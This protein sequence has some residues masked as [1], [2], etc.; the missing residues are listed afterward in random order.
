MAPGSNACPGPR[1]SESTRQ[2]YSAPART[3]GTKTCQIGPVRFLSASSRTSPRGTPP[4]AISASV[5]RVAAGEWTAK[6]TPRRSSVAPS[7]EGEPGSTTR[8]A[9]GGTTDSAGS[10]LARFMESVAA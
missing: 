1:T 2:Q 6:L 5:T 9:P 8:A 4:G 7:G 10:S 3:P